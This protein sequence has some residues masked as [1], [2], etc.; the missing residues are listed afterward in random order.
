MVESTKRNEFSLKYGFIHKK[1]TYQKHCSIFFSTLYLFILRTN[2]SYLLR[3]IYKAEMR[4]GIW[5]LFTLVFS[6]WT[7]QTV[8]ECLDQMYLEFIILFVKTSATSWFLQWSR[9]SLHLLGFPVSTVIGQSGRLVL[10]KVMSVVFDDV[11]F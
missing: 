7:L 1:F 3:R 8:V 4:I 10:L 2:N 9:I 6:P 5:F 11:K